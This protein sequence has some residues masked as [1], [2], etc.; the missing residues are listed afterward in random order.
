MV[1]T[2]TLSRA[3]LS[4]N[5]LEIPEEEISHYVHKVKA[6]LPISGS[7]FEQF[8]NETNAHPTLQKLKKYVT[9]GWPNSQDEVEYSVK[10][11]FNYRDEISELNGVLLKVI[12]QL[13]YHQACNLK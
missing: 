13:L 4:D 3:M 12:Q 10:Q 9:S 6:N 11:Y 2:D 7:K 8:V 5:T 1:V